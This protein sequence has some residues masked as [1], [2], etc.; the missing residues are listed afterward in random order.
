MPSKNLIKD[1]KEDKEIMT[2]LETLGKR[3]AELESD[4]SYERMFKER[5]EN[6]LVEYKKEI[7]KL[8]DQLRLDNEF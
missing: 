7:D 8:K 1:E 4:L 6:D 2:V 3:I 5:A